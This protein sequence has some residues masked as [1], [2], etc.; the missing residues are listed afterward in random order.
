MSDILST[1]FDVVGGRDDGDRV[2]DVK[3]CDQNGWVGSATAQLRL[4]RRP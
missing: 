1:S 3:A 2:I 4:D